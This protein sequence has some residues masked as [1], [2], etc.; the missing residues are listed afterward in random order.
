[1]ASSM[2]TLPPATGRRQQAL[3]ALVLVVFLLTTGC[4]EPVE[5]SQAAYCKELSRRRS[6]LQPPPGAALDAVYA[7]AA[8]AYDALEPRAPEEVGDDV[9]RTTRALRQLAEL[10][11]DAA[12]DD[13]ADVDGRKLVD[14]ALSAKDSTD[15]VNAY[16]RDRCGVDTAAALS[17]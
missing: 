11:G 6:E 4:S 12:G 10:T 2:R 7:D 13:P 3:G 16:N 17:P 15:R 5:R 9:A 14:V 1:M 8:R